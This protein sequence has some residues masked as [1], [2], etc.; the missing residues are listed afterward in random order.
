MILQAQKG[1]PAAQNTLVQDNIGLVWSIVRRF[2]GREVETEDLF[3]IGCIGL[4][5]A[6][7][8]FDP[9][10]EVRFSTYAV[11]M[12]MGEIKRFL[13]DDG[14]IKV[15]RALKELGQKHGSAGSNEKKLANVDIHELADKLDVDLK[16]WFR[17]WNPGIS[18]NSLLRRP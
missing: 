16:N 1:D 6:I 3:Q 12:I 9:A 14:A 10:F 7:K 8:K 15:S 2:R 13:R 17:H 18:P 4:V 11:P 5:K